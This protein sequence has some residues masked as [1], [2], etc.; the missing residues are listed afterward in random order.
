MERWHE[1]EAPR[2]FEKAGR[3]WEDVRGKMKYRVGFLDYVEFVRRGRDG[4][5]DLKGEIGVREREMRGELEAFRAAR[6][7]GEGV[8]EG[9]GVGVGVEV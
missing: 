3:E 5:G 6:G 1:K 8:G 2:A 7:G 9:V 4:F